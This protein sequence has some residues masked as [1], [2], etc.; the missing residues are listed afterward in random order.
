MPLKGYYPLGEEI[1]EQTSGGVN[2][3]VHGVGTAHSIHGVTES[4]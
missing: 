3:F 4:L 2:A 1:W